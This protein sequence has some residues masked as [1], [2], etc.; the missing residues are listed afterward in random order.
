V[1]RNKRKPK[2]VKMKKRRRSVR[3]PY[4]CEEPPLG[5]KNGG[6]TAAGGGG[7]KQTAPW[8]GQGLGKSAAAK[9]PP[10]GGAHKRKGGEE[11]VAQTVPRI[12]GGKKTR[13]EEEPANTVLGP[14]SWGEGSRC[15]DTVP[16]KSVRDKL[17]RGKIFGHFKGGGGLFLG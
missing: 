1:Q 5:K 2:R 16:D 17:P 6:G 8:L 9:N 7:G 3:G 11:P 12:R 13:T 4:K 10:S 14:A 15:P